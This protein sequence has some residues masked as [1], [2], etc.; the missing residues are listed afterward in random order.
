MEIQ[1]Q[2]LIEQIKRDGVE[3]AEAR[4]AEILDAA[5]AEAQKIVADAKK[6]AEEIMQ[7]AKAEND[8]FVRVGED[9][10][11]QAAR[12][13][14]ISFRESIAR[15]LNVIIGE[16]VS[17]A[18]S[19]EALSKLIVDAVAAFAQRPDIEDV[20]VLL[21]AENAEALE[22]ALLSALKARMLEGVTVKPRGDFDGGFRIAVNGGSAYYDYSA[23]AVSDM[24]SAYLAPKVTA[25]LKEAQEV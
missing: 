19:N 18:Y 7:K 20:C 25:L 8:R 5:N 14:L 17:T 6:N 9:A 23:E 11:K 2:E 16:K 4:A 3:S 1:L 22:N 24:L 15:E 10:L 21:G 13:L 12:N